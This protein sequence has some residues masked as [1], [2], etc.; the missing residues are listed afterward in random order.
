[1]TIKS[2][3]LQQIVDNNRDKYNPKNVK[4]QGVGMSV[5][6]T[7]TELVSPVTQEPIE[8]REKA[9]E[10]A[11]ENLDNPAS[12]PISQNSQPEKLDIEQV[13][14][15]ILQDQ[16][17]E[18]Q[19]PWE[20][21]GLTKANYDRLSGNYSTSEL[22]SWYGYNSDK[23]DN[24]LEKLYRANTPPPTR[25]IEPK[26]AK[27]RHEFA[28]IADALGLLVQTIGYNNK[29]LPGK[30]QTGA[31]NL[32]SEYNKL[33]AQYQSQLE[34]YNKGLSDAV[35]KDYLNAM[36]R[37]T[38]GRKEAEGYL[39]A[40]RKRE[41]EA[42][43]KEDRL[44]LDRDKFEYTQQKDKDI[45]DQRK[46]NDEAR[47]RIARG[48]LGLDGKKLELASQREARIKAQ[49]EATNSNKKSGSGSSK[50]KATIVIN[51]HEDDTSKNVRSSKYNKSERQRYFDITKGEVTQ[52]AVEARTNKEFQKTAEYK[53][54]KK[55]DIAT[56]SESWQHDDI[57]ASSYL[58]WK[59]DNDI[60]Q[61]GIA[62]LIDSDITTVI[63]NNNSKSEDN[64]TS[65][66]NVEHTDNNNSNSSEL[67]TTTMELLSTTTK[68]N[69]SK[70]TYNKFKATQFD[71][72]EL[73][74]D[75]KTKLKEHNI[76]YVPA[77]DTDSLTNTE[78]AEYN[79][80]RKAYIRAKQKAGIKP[81]QSEMLDLLSI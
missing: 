3:I 76:E 81:T 15:S 1:M 36:E 53:N 20:K 45:L 14:K 71:D 19:E 61:F 48:K 72:A 34:R 40:T 51:A 6:G 69:E 24:M 74:N 80:D 37:R 27:R 11:K 28:Q 17:Q 5:D 23:N 58:Q 16:P 30:L 65:S 26:E 7:P 31:D 44:K 68:Q 4:P 32:K 57:V 59:Y 66:N 46:E 42:K 56:G 50:D 63:D 60:E 54:L 75:A 73:T 35:G 21:L 67:S 12:T 79:K 33:N 62:D 70:P 13:E 38:K 78:L 10:A 49:Q 22:E 39:N 29:A 41:E 9:I 64:E 52:L 47:N 25:T 2:N 43:A 77:L 8:V 18:K 55:K